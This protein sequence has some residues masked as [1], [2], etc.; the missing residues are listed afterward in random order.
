MGVS[1]HSKEQVFDMSS[2]PKNK[3]LQGRLSKRSVKTLASS[4]DG[5]EVIKM[6]LFAQHV[7]PL[8]WLPVVM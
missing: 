1:L 2:V 8:P 7:S 5:H 3:E 4:P 6:F